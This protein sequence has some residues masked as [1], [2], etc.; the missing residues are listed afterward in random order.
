MLLDLTKAPSFFV[1]MLALYPVVAGAFFVPGSHWQDRLLLA[2][3]R[4]GLAGCLALVSGILFARP[5]V[6]ESSA[7]HDD[8][9]R[10]LLASL[11]V[12][13]YLWTILGVTILF[14][15]S[16]YLEEFYMPY[17]LKNLPY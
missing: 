7:G 11:P 13:I 16:W 9:G 5:W 8:A 6:N 17:S 10:R 14:L 4:M 15:L 3:A 1:S 2:L 12:R